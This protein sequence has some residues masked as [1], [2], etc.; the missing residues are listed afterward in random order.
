MRFF[1]VVV[2]SCMLYVPST[3]A[4]CS[5]KDVECLAPLLLPGYGEI[6]EGLT[7]NH[8]QDSIE[9]CIIPLIEKKAS[10]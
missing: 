1:I 8:K 7:R 10:R 2:L 4:A 5:F 9:L 6:Y 3:F